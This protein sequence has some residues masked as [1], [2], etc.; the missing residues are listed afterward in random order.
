MGRGFCRSSCQERIWGL[1]AGA[2]DYVCKPFSAR[3][4]ALLAEAIL[5]R[6]RR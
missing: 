6:Y 3:V 2:D 1:A 5:K 4:L